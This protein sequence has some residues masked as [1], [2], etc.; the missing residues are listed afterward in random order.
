MKKDLYAEK[1]N[2][3]KINKVYVNETLGFTSYLKDWQYLVLNIPSIYI[4]LNKAISKEEIDKISKALFNTACAS[5]KT[6]ID[7]DTIIITLPD[8][9]KGSPRWCEL[10]SAQLGGAIAILKEDGYG[11]LDVCP[12][13]YEKADY[14]E[15]G[16]Q[17]I[18][19]HED[20]K[21]VVITK[22]ENKIKEENKKLYLCGISLL[23]SFIFSLIGIVP[24]LLL[25]YFNND[26]FTGLVALVPILNA[27][28][29]F[30]IKA[31]NN[32]YLRF[33]TSIFPLIVIGVFCFY[34][35]PHNM[36]GLNMDMY[37]YCFTNGWVG[38]RKIIFLTLFSIGGFG[39]VKFFSKFK[40]DYQKE[41]D[42]IK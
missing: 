1:I 25:S 4:P 31:P 20:C 29:Y 3:K 7:N 13:C 5:C 10:A 11:P 2:Y 17:Y 35:F 32:K 23:V 36:Q 41:L 22:I 37:Q 33:I 8:G 12:I 15:F 39:T 27:L 24:A 28:G 38:F 34:I 16:D 14:M 9:K 6:R 40:I 21:N 26:F 19:L 18:P 30:L 42:K